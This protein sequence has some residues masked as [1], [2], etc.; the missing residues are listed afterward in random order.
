M[1]GS[2]HP[3]AAGAC[4]VATETFESL[5]GRR[6]NCPSPFVMPAWMR[7]WREIFAPQADL[8]IR[9]FQE[10]GQV[11]GV[12]PLRVQNR[13]ATLI[14]DADVCDH[15]DL[16]A[17]GG[18]TGEWYRTL[19]RELK[20][21]GI[22]RL[23]LNPLRP[24]SAVMTALIPAARE[25]G[26][27]VLTREDGVL[28]ELDLPDSWVEY[29]QIL[30][31]KQRHEVRRKERRLANSAT[32]GFRVLE[33]PPSVRAAMDDFIGLFRQN[34]PEKA[35]FMSNQMEA[36]F[37]RLAEYVPEMRIGLLDVDDAPAAAVLCCDHGGTRYLYN[38][39]YKAN[40]GHLSVGLLCKIFSIRESIARGLKRY[41]FLK[42]DEMYKRQLGGGPV[43][44]YSC[45]IDLT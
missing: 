13:T 16:I 14:G 22:T 9:T 10:N 28:F 45:R 39:G 20:A 26:C 23:E 21:E 42:G 33:K 41:D 30:S 6:L 12:A 18:R 19:L 4:T 43:P 15:L 35:A 40:L 7:A 3:T 24:D 17:V 32:A 29:L 38:S 8:W 27:A 2:T 36:Y 34:R 31:G 25:E 1:P 44:I 11:A 5:A 37:R